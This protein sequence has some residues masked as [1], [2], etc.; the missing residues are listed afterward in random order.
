MKFTSSLLSLRVDR[1]YL[2][3]SGREQVMQVLVVYAASSHCCLC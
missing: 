2:R 3:I 1:G